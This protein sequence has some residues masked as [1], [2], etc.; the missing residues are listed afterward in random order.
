ML[1]A[2]VILRLVVVFLLDY[3]SISVGWVLDT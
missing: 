1:D 3:T 2:D